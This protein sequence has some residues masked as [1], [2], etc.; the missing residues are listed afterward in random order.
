M[1]HYLRVLA[2]IELSI[3]FRDAIVLCIIR[4]SALGA[5]LVSR[6]RI[7]KARHCTQQKRPSILV[8]FHRK[9]FVAAVW[10]HSVLT[11]FCGVLGVVLLQKRCRAA[12]FDMYRGIQSRFLA[13]QSTPQT[14]P[15]RVFLSGFDGDDEQMHVQYPALPTLP[16][17]LS[18]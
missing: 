10:C 14:I 2:F 13:V 1:M 16:N 18:L 5:G 4:V 12:D 3:P 11:S 8:H 9:M 7:R 15:V 17:G 6:V